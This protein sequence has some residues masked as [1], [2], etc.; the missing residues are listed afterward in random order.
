M[1][2]QDWRPANTCGGDLTDG[3]EYGVSCKGPKTNLAIYGSQLDQEKRYLDEKEKNID[4]APKEYTPKSNAVEPSYH[5][6]ARV[7]NCAGRE[8]RFVS[9]ALSQLKQESWLGPMPGRSTAQA[10]PPA[11]SEN[12]DTGLLIDLFNSF[13]LDRPLKD[14]EDFSKARKA[15]TILGKS[16]HGNVK[17]MQLSAA[18]SILD[19]LSV[20][21]VPIDVR[22]KKVETDKEKSDFAFLNPGKDAHGGARN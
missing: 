19:G 5:R 11:P 2:R 12:S 22:S 4:K 8:A 6:Q 1:V 14:E 7:H 16:V 10:K 9:P 15:T 20:Q 13:V 17:A 3:G 18:K 21:D